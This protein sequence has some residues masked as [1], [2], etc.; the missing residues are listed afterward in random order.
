MRATNLTIGLV[1]FLAT[2]T[3][4]NRALGPLLGINI[5]SGGEGVDETRENLAEDVD[6]GVTDG[7]ELSPISAIDLLT[8]MISNLSNADQIL[9]NFGLPPEV[10][11]WITSPLIIVMAIA[12]V[13]LVFRTRF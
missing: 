5:A 12:L 8:D 1:A 9:M 10:A 11:A 2:I 13:S 6:A 7:G 3:F 4:V